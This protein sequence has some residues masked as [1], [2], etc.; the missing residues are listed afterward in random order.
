[1][2]TP[3]VCVCVGS[4][5]VNIEQLLHFLS[6]KEFLLFLLS[7]PLGRVSFFSSGSENLH[8][9]EKVMWGTRYA[10]TVSFTCDPAHAI[11]DPA[12]P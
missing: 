9:V 11:S 5:S 10:I 8:R 7:P 2:V 1:M 3:A 6:P 4:E 12:L